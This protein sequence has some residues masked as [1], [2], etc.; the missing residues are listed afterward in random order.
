M[1]HIIGYTLRF[2]LYRLVWPLFAWLGRFRKPDP[3]L[4]LFLSEQEECMN[5]N[6]GPVWDSL[7]QAGYDC[8]FFGRA[9]GTGLSRK[10]RQYLGTFKLL[11]LYARCATVF[12]DES[13][14]ITNAV[15]PQYWQRIVQLWHGCGAFKRWGYS[16]MDK[17]WGATPLIARLFPMHRNYSH[18]LVSS[19]E[20]IPF[21]KDAY[22]CP[23]NILRP[24]GV[25][26]TDAYFAPDFAAAS[27]QT[28]MEAFPE[29]GQRKIIVYAPTFRGNRIADAAFEDALDISVLQEMLGTECALLL[30]PHPRVKQSL[31]A[32]PEGEVPFAFDARSLPIEALLG[33]ADLLISDYSSLIFEYALLK[34]PML[35]YAYDLDAYEASRSFYEPYI[36]FVPG[37]LCWSSYDVAESAYAALF[38]AGFDTA[39]LDAFLT[40]YMRSCDGHSTQRLLVQLGLLPK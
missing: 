13:H 18:A 26:R 20:V 16:T 21:H 29:I 37:T 23:P 34:R 39:Q 5:G 27:R 8:R 24:W 7:T 10:L 9:P 33:A 31:P 11:L 19:P 15:K 30:R 28:V 4:I 1:K 6:F 14:A 3:Q 38:G 22:R 12:L 25:P 40:R 35:F 32:Y 36:S 17:E 2:I